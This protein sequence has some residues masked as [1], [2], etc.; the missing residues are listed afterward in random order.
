MLYDIAA[1][2]YLYGINKTG[3]TAVN[4]KFEFSSSAPLQTLYSKS[5]TDV[6]DLSSV[7]SPTVVNLNAGTFSSIKGV[8]NIAIA[9]GSKIN[10]VTLNRTTGVSDE[11]YINQAFKQSSFDVISNLTATDIIDISPTILG[12]LSSSNLQIGDTSTAQSSSKK[13]IV[14]KST[15]E[16]FYDADGS[17]AKASVK[18][19]A[20]TTAETF[21]I[22]QANFLFKA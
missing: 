2:Q 6:I 12:G 21:T 20:Y 3:S 18:L 9:Y 5:G 19:A 8:N 11:I 4:N 15:G 13:L 7:S 1:L 16:I 22:T 10:K 14:N 17:G